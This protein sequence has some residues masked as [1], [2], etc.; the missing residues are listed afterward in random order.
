MITYLLLPFAAMQAFSLISS[1]PLMLAN[2]L[3]LLF[4]AAMIMS[5]VYVF[6]SYRFYRTGM[7]LGQRQQPTA[8][9]WLSITAQVARVYA[10]LMILVAFIFLSNQ[11]IIADI[12][13]QN[14]TLA[15]RL[16][17]SDLDAAGVVAAMKYTFLF[18]GLL[19]L[20]LLAHVSMTLK[21]LKQYSA[22]FDDPNKRDSGDLL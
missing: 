19:S 12:L 5:V 14:P 16:K 21:L 2:P 1:L 7:R 22:L 10:V 17:D 20:L 18:F 11:E 13:Q 6:L 3:G 9:K 4:G 8:K 15:E